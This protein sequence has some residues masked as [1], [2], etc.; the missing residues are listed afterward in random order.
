MS[1]CWMDAKRLCELTVEG[2]VVEEGVGESRPEHGLVFITWLT[3][4]PSFIMQIDGFKA[5]RPTGI[6]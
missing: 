1:R 6:D 3:S 5:V 4:W 2:H